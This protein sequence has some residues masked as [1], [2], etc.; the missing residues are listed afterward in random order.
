MNADNLEVAI[1][2]GWSCIVQKGKY[3]PGDHVVF[4]PPDSVIPEE[5][6]KKYEL[7]YL[8]GGGRV[9][10]IKLRGQ[11]SQGIALQVPTKDSGKPYKLGANLADTFG[12]K[13]YEPTIKIPIK[14]GFMDK[15]KKKNRNDKFHKYTD[16]ENLNHY[17]SI[18][19]KDDVVV[20]TEKIHGTNFRAGMVPINTKTIIGKLKYLIGKKYEFVY[21]SRNMQLKNYS[22]K[23]FYQSNVYAIISRRYNLDKIIP[24]GVVLYG[25]IYGKGIQDLDYGEDGI[26]LVIFDVMEGGK[27]MSTTDASAIVKKLGLRSVPIL[28]IGYY[29]DDVGKKFADGNSVMSKTSQIREG[30]VIKPYKQEE[31]DRKIGRKILKSINQEYL[32]RKNRTEFQ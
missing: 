9:T 29:V 31:I 28:Y 7:D 23:T 21:G 6:I 2:K 14:Y 16:I 32:C 10:T 26:D 13:K 8:K 22:Q 1:I 3:K 19:T 18:F 5:M 17:P 20:I 4:I 11:I 25:E 27:Y 15:K 12:I 30:C 24:S